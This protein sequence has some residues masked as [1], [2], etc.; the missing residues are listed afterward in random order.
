MIR[1]ALATIAILVS[2]GGEAAG[3]VL[4]RDNDD[5]PIPEPAENESANYIWWD[6]TWTMT[7]YQLRK[8][9]DLGISL[10]TVGEWLHVASPREAKNLNSLD[11]APD[12][13]WFT[14]RHGRR[15][16]SA[17]ELARGPNQG[18]DPAAGGPLW[19]LSGKAHGMTPGFVM[20]DSKDDQ[21]VVKLDPAAYPEVPT[22]AEIVCTKILHALGWN[23][24]E[25]YLFR[26]DPARLVIDDTAWIKDRYR[27]K[28]RFTE[29]DL[30][31][32]LGYATQGRDGS[33]RTLASRFIP[34]EAKG[35][36]QTLGLRRDDPNDTVPH[37]DRRELRGLRVVAAWINFTD[38]RRGNFLDG[39]VEHA[40]RTDGR[41]HLVHYVLDFSSALGSGN[42][43]WK[44]PQYGHEYYFD[45][46]KVLF[47]ML[48]LGLVRPVWADVPLAHPALGY[49]DSETFDPEGWVTT[50]PN[51]LF[52]QSTVRDSFWGT[53]LVASIGDGDLRVIIATGEWSDPTAAE[54][55]FEILRERRRKIARAY[56]DWR[57]INP[58]DD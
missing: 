8:V 20:K 9:F 27:R 19:I 22:G 25:N 16:L 14:N 42:D 51:P 21:Y 35:P 43:D 33:V 39:F 36:F 12:S 55:L 52:D 57:R 37:E 7:Y 6:G 24:P 18:R 40:G 2:L 23:V 13:T 5:Q 10:R 29:Q 28:R 50:Y 17:T 38:A 30:A 49:L 54:K 56:F 58:V 45:P 31:R 4:W 48:M 15:R 46:P 26:L 1:G 53:K 44:S 41:G 34:G 47:R 32:L 3:D 11:E